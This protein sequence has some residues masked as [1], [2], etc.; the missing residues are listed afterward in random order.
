[1][2]VHNQ[3]DVPGGVRF[4]AGHGPAPVLGPCPHDDCR[5]HAQSVI[6]WGPNW[7]RYEMLACDVDDGCAGGCRGWKRVTSWTD[8]GTVDRWV[9]VGEQ[10]PLYTPEER[11]VVAPIENDD[12][13]ADDG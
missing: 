6:A 1:M 7:D 4:S 5:H 12:Q 8:N 11:L 3:V 9:Q 13:E 2:G 10:T